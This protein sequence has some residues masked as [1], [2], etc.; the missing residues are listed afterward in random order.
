MKGK[1]ETSQLL[2]ELGKELQQAKAH[3]GEESKKVHDLTAQL[4][5]SW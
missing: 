2:T 5:V 4:E 3:L 1:D